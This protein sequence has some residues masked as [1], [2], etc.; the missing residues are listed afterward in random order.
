NGQRP[1][2]VP[3]SEKWTTS[4][5]SPAPD[6]RFGAVSYDIARS[7]D[8]AQINRSRALADWLPSVYDRSGLPK[9]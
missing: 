9:R 8:I 5:V 7:A 1:H 3:P 4:R 6:R 2:Q